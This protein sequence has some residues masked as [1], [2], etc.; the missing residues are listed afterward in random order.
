MDYILECIKKY[1]TSIRN[2]VPNLQEIVDIS[3]N[4]EYRELCMDV[5]TDIHNNVLHKEI[6][7]YIA[8]RLFLQRV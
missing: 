8:P 1:Q 7:K 2:D 4:A 6:L 3:N 5:I